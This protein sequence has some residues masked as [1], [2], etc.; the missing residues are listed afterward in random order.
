MTPF[1]A[2][3]KIKQ[4]FAEAGELPVEQA[5]EPM[6]SEQ[7]TEAA[8]EYVL[9][10]GVKVMIDKLEVGGKVSVLDEAGNMAPAP[11]GE[12]ILADGTKITVDESGSIVAIETP[13]SETI[14]EVAPEAAPAPEMM[15]NEEMKS[16]IEEMQKQLDEMKSKFEAAE[17]KSSEIEAKFSKGI[18]ELSDVLIQLMQTSSSAPTEQPKEKFNVHVESKDSKISRFLELAKSIK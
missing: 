11:I 16:K 9:Q 18:S 1:E 2:I 12:H 7:P 8:K 4:M 10:S 5:G 3:Q 13:I 17:S 14:E 6:P 15:Q